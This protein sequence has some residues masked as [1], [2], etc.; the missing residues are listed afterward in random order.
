[1]GLKFNVNKIY[2]SKELIFCFFTIKML[3]G[4]HV[5]RAGSIL[6]REETEN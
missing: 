6:K 3:K 1:M 5:V 2:N 4:A